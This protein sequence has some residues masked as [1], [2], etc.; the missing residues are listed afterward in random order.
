MAYHHDD[1]DP[2]WFWREKSD[3]NRT[4]PTLCV[5]IDGVLADAT[6]RQHLLESRWRDWD[7]FFEAADGDALLTEQSALLDT[8]AADHVIALVTARPAW[9]SDLT[10]AWLA[11]HDVRWDLLVMRSNGDFRQ[12]PAMKTAAVEQLVTRDLEPVLAMDDDARNV[13]AYQ[14]LGIPCVYIHSGYHG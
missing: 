6:H 2:S 7:S 13:A 4:G 3:Q 9:I 8:V 14:R 11:E 10:I 12:S 1:E 5:D